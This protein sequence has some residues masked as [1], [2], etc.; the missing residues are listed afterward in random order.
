MGD[1]SVFPIEHNYAHIRRSTATERPL[2][3]ETMIESY[4]WRQELRVDLKWLRQ[5][6]KYQ[7]WSE[8]QMV[9]FERRLILVAVQIRVLI[10]QQR[11]RSRLAQ[12]RLACTW[13]PKSGNRPVTRFNAHRLHT[14]F[15]LDRPESVSLTATEVANQLVHHYEMYAASEGR[16]FSQILVFSDR[17]RDK[18]LYVIDVPALLDFL[19]R[20]SED[21]SAVSSMEATW[22]PTK[23][24]YDVVLD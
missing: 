6:S 13:Y 19:S 4:Y 15:G 12:A 8:K 5:H 14:H 3:G 22:N 1:R 10:E 11:V 7:R 21:A 23:R 2:G 17:M 9:L 16:T 20:F 24:D 18:G